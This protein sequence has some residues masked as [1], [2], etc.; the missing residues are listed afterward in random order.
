MQ[1]IV[2]KKADKKVYKTN[3]F[4]QKARFDLTLTQQKL[5]LYAISK[6][7]KSSENFEKI[8]INLKEFQDICNVTQKDDTGLKQD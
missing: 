5:I 8:K 2:Q 1:K 7:N 6:I 3:E 4:I